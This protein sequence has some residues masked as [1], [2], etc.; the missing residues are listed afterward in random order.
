[1]SH[2]WNDAG[3]QQGPRSRRQRDG[4]DVRRHGHRDRLTRAP[5]GL[6]IAAT[7]GSVTLVVNRIINGADIALTLVAIFGIWTGAAAFAAAGIRTILRLATTNAAK[8]A[9]IP[10][11]VR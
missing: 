4:R 8:R 9:A 5:Q 2:E 7:T 1:M 3:L 6:G 11:I 10:A